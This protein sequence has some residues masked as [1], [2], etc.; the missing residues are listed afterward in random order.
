MLSSPTVRD[1]ARRLLAYE[2]IAGT[3]SR[4]TEPATL[5]VYEK[6]RRQLSAPVGADGFQA[7]A[8]RALMLAKS[9]S[10]KKL[11]LVHIA[12]DGSLHGLEG[13]SEIDTD[14]DG[15]PGVVLIAQ[16]LG[17][18]LT[19]LGEATTLRL[20]E[21][22]RLQA[23]DEPASN[24]GSEMTILS[25][26]GAVEIGSGATD[27]F[28]SILRE[29]DKLRSASQALEDLAGEYPDMEDGLVTVAGNIRNIATV[30]D[31]F[32]LVRSKFEKS[33]GDKKNPFTPYVM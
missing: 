29:V 24:I 12:A 17:L 27:G 14:L 21:D 22:V 25:A 16:L 18:V 26:A 4:L 31:V 9:Q 5:R 6:L 7:L 2:D 33:K 20:I 28:E 15:H 1:W 32:V 23:E 8:S 19:L 30:L 13:A 11:G 10:P 3:A